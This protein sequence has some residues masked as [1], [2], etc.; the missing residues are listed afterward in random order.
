[1]MPQLL[2]HTLLWFTSLLLHPLI[3]MLVQLSRG[4]MCIIPCAIAP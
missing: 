1:M 2:I 4:H 3:M